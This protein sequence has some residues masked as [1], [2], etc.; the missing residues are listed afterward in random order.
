MRTTS[1]SSGI[2]TTRSF[3]V[4]SSGCKN[5]EP[6]FKS[7]RAIALEGQGLQCNAR[8]S[9]FSCLSLLL[10]LGERTRLCSALRGQLQRDGF[11]QLA[12]GAIKVEEV[13]V[14]TMKVPTDGSQ[15]ALAIAA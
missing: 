12:P 3:Y 4:G 2:G 14:F 1:K 8:H 13:F 10:A 7:I 11:V 9:H 15:A 6:P 5:D